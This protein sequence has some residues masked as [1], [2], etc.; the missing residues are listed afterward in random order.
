M[1]SNRNIMQTLQ[2]VT[3]MVFN[4]VVVTFKKEEV[5]VILIMFHYPNIAKIL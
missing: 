4:L 2:C 1:L 5:R 3:C